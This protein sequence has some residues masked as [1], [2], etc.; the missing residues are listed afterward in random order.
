MK[1]LLLACLTATILFACN[2]E[3][4]KAEVAKNSDW[5]GDNL[6]GMVQSIEETD[7]T[8]DST[9]KIGEMDSCCIN[10]EQYDNKG[11]ITS[12]TQ[13]DSKGNISEESTMARY[14]K[15]QVK[16]FSNTKDGK[17]TGGFKIQVDDMG[18]YSGAQE[19][20]STGN[21]SFFYTDLGEDENGAVTTGKRHKADST[22]FGTFYN[23]YKNGV[24]VGNRFTDSTGKEVSNSKSELNDK[25]DVIKRTNTNVGKDSTVTKVTTYKYD[26][27][28]ET[29]NWTQRSTYDEA[30]K[31][32]KVTKRTLTYYKED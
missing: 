10:V 11:Y 6:K 4:K 23:E 28:D 32:T 27:Y 2:N 5:F 1:K 8:P 17:M 9:G 25:N 14:E 21:V 22:F 13:K 3:E 16:E 18:K 31:L 24:Q 30:G 12:N 7:Y 19:I 26:S 20:D 15:G 29:G